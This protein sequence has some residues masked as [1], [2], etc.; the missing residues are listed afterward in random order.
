MTSQ[1]ARTFKTVD[2]YAKVVQNLT[3][4]FGIFTGVISLFA[5]QYDRRVARTVDMTKLYSEQIRDKYLDLAAKWR[6]ASVQPGFYQQS[7]EKMKQFV[8]EFFENQDNDKLLTNYLDFFDGLAVCIENGA[9]DRNSAI[10]YFSHT[11]RYVCEM[12]FPYLEKMRKDD[13]DPAFGAGLERFCL[14]KRESFIGRY[15]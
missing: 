1:G 10:D 4:I 8:L 15:L 7:E 12:S 11:A 9:C 2:R 6:A 13:R 5:T 3:I 14:L